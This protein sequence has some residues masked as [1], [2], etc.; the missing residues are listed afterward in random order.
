[1]RIA[2]I[3]PFLD[4]EAVLDGLLSSIAAQER[5]PD[6]LVLVD[7]GSRDHGPEIAAAF[8][9]EHSW[10]WLLRRPP[11]SLGRDRLAACGELVGFAWAAEQVH[12]DI[13]GKVD[14]DLVLPPDFL[15]ELERRF[16]ADQR[17]GIAGAELSELRED[18]RRERM[19]APTGHVH[20]ASRLYRRA[21]WAAIAPVPPILGWDTIDLVR[22][23]M[24]GWRTASF[25]IPSGDPL[26]ERRMGSHD[27]LLRGYRRAGEAAWGYGSAPWMVAL[28]AIARTRDHPRGLAAAHFAFAWARAAGRRAP[29]ATPAERAWLRREHASRLRDTLSGHERERRLTAPK[30][31][32]VLVLLENQPYPYDARVRAEVK[33]MRT[34]GYRVTVVG[35]TGAG[36]EALEEQ[37]DGVRVLRFRAPPS[38]RGIYNYAV[39][40][41]V[42]F[43]RLRTLTRRIAREDRVDAVLVCNPPD[44]LVELA[45][46]FARRGA[47]VVLDDRELSP[48]LFEV[49]FGR[50]GPVH[51]LLVAVERR[52]FHAADATLVTNASYIENVT[53][54]AGLPR[55]RVF[56]VGNGPDPRRIH[57][58][59]PRPELRR[60]RAHLVLWMGA[61][62]T[63]EGLELLVQA[64]GELVQGRGRDDITFALVG[65]GDV[66][67]L[68]E[69]EIVR[70][71]LE[72]VVE[73][74]GRQ[75]DDGV[76][77]Y[78]ATADVCV[79]TDQPNPMNDRAAMRKVLEYMAAGRPV[80]QFPLAEMRRL[81]GDATLWATPGDPLSL[82]SQIERLLD[83]PAL[84]RRVGEAGRARVHD[85]LMWPDQVQ[86]LL[87]ALELAHLRARTRR[88]TRPP[89]PS[90][91]A[92][93]A[94]PAT[95]RP[96]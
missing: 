40:F 15:A 38:G 78:L 8:A 65:P 10:A 91:P 29:R 20:G 31:P 13:V 75:D 18:G 37:L 60:G 49:K 87:R 52:A 86:S 23:R 7:D 55:D 61:M 76:R 89:A 94:R 5:R 24:Q 69:E 83:D 53:R 68:L 3:V 50:R 11:R 14:A 57:P 85:G 33:A 48:E 90:A 84:R 46:P 16:E 28:A 54:R 44:F 25:A 43:V 2:L 32:H 81:C 39:E 9:R 64:A 59:P 66:H 6:A 58:V 45:R 71:G 4:E 22:A 88:P 96:R 67:D 73:L 21:C 17:L 34:A 36:F 74:A 27:G 95:A 70:C 42:S 72:G 79:N 19:R 82:A 30:A 77:A 92:P 1:V 26:H 41:G 80:V 63:Q 93:A 12:A 47:G 35:P 62:S 56:V 51:A